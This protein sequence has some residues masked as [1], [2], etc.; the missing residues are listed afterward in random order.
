[1]TTGLNRK[2]SERRDRSRLAYFIIF[3][4]AG[5]FLIDTAGQLYEPYMKTVSTGVGVSVKMIGLILAIRGFMGLSSP[6]I[7]HLADKRGYKPFLAGSLIIAGL[8]N[9]AAGFK[10]NI[11]AYLSSMIS[12]EKR[13]RGLGILEYSYALAGIAG[14]LIVRFFFQFGIGAGLLGSTAASVSGPAAFLR[15]G[16]WGITPVGIGALAVT[17]LLLLLFVKERS[18][19]E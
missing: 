12:Y 1:M 9:I 8:G 4:M 2:R 18:K 13:G 19:T 7:G 14:L 15:F 10:P 6:I 17:L 16:V 11:H 5:K 3:G